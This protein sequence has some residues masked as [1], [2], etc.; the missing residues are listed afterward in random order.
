MLVADRPRG[1]E[2]KNLKIPTNTTRRW[3]RRDLDENSFESNSTSML[4]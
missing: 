2:G 1:I 4:N 3:A